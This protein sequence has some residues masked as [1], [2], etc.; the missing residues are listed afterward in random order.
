MTITVRDKSWKAVRLAVGKTPRVGVG[1]EQALT[2]GGGFF[3][4]TA[5]EFRSD[6]R[7]GRAESQHPQPDI[8]IG[9]GQSRA[10][11]PLF[12]EHYRD[13]AG[14]QTLRDP[15]DGIFEDPGMSRPDRL[16]PFGQ[17]MH[18]GDPGSPL[19]Q[20]GHLRVCQVR[21]NVPRPQ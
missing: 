12:I 15:G 1:A 8:R 5:E 17:Q 3:R 6:V 16:K 2:A 20:S 14:F 13:I 19:Q 9:I 18:R 10:E 4:E 21:R 7:G 11:L